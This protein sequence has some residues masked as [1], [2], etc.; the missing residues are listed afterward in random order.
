MSKTYFD[1]A[2]ERWGDTAAWR[3]FEERSVSADDAADGL[4]KLFA[5]LGELKEL[6]PDSNEVQAAVKKIQQYITE[7]FYKCTDEIFAGLG[8]M[9]VADE[10]FKKNIDKAGGAGTARF[11]RDAIRIYCNKAV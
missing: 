6:P 5:K 9:Y 2:K 4:M 11:A 8:E 10:R 1:E 7:H 3:E